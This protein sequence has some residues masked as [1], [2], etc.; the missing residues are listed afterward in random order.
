ME[1]FEVDPASMR[2]AAQ[3]L[4]QV[5]ERLGSEWQSFASGMLS[6][7]DVFGDDPVGGL[8][9]AS[10]HAAHDLAEKCYQSGVQALG[11]FGDGLSQ[12]AAAY[13]QVERQIT[14]LFKQFKEA[15]G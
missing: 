12:M 6:R 5:G 14:D 3:R 1:G 2:D 13:D 8:I 9:G 15:I 11:G 10:Y 7:G 4:Q